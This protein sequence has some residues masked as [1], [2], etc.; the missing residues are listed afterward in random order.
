M[1]RALIVSLGYLWLL[2]AKPKHVSGEAVS[3]DKRGH[4]FYGSLQLKGSF[5]NDDAD[6]NDNGKNKISETTT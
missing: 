3:C 5:S 6:G 4:I 2:H 1:F